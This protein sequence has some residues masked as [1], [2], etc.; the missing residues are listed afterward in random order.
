[1]SLIPIGTRVRRCGWSRDPHH[2]W[3]GT[4]VDHD[5]N[6]ENMQNNLRYNVIEW[7]CSAGVRSFWVENHAGIVPLGAIELLGE[8]SAKIEA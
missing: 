1:M 8:L 4:V 5:H 2:G 3:T 7:D 6:I